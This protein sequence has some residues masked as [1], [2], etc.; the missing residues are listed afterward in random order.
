MGESNIGV[1]LMISFNKILEIITNRF[2]IWIFSNRIP[3]MATIILVTIITLVSFVLVYRY[4]SVSSDL[5]SKTQHDHDHLEIVKEE[6]ERSESTIGQSLFYEYYNIIKGYFVNV[7]S[8]VHYP[9]STITEKILDKEK[10][11]A[12]MDLDKITSELSDE[13]IE[14]TK[15]TEL[16]EQ[17]KIATQRNEEAEKNYANHI[18]QRP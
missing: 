11:D 16:E 5:K 4:S 17:L 10:K 13:E 3:G 2:I 8:Q 18:S 1:I 6:I 12:N 7:G 15:K 14:E 9:Y